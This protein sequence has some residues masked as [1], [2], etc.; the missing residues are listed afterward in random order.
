MPN[1]YGTIMMVC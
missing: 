1:I